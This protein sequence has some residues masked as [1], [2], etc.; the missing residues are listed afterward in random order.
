M[1]RWAIAIL[2]G[3]SILLFVSGLSQIGDPHPPLVQV[4][5]PTDFGTIESAPRSRST[6][7]SVEIANRSNS[8]VKL[9]GSDDFCGVK[10]CL[11]GSGF[12]YTI[13]PHSSSRIELRV[14]SNQPGR[15]ADTI[16]LYTD[17]PDLPRFPVKVVG[18]VIEG[19]SPISLR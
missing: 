9:V 6:A 16:S 7:I 19:A 18:Q 13:A 2:L 17:C 15:Y 11:K 10:G 1:L 14:S 12:P 3:S 8:Q 5:A 4:S